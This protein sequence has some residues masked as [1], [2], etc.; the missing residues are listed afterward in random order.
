[1]EEVKETKFFPLLA[2]E[3]E[4]HHIE[5][6]PISLRFV[7][8]DCNIKEEFLEFGKCEQMVNLYSKK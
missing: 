3:V 7:D 4:N 8:K 1:M 2:D 6:L 5:Q